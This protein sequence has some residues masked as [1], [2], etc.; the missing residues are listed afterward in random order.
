M[1]NNKYI[2]RLKGGVLIAVASVMIASCNDTWDDHYKVT[3]LSN[4]KTLWTNIQE[5]SE[6]AE[7]AR[8]L[9]ACGYDRKLGSAEM[10]TV[11]APVIDQ[12]TADEWIAT[13][14]EDEEK[15][16]KQEDNRTVVQFL[17]NHIALYNRS[18]P[19]ELSDSITLVNGKN[20]KMTTRYVASEPVYTYGTSEF[21][22]RNIVASN[23][24]L[25]KLN[26][27]EAYFPNIWE[28]IQMEPDFTRISAYISSFNDYYLDT[29]ASVPGG[30]NEDGQIEYLDSVTYFYNNLLSSLGYINREDSAY[31]MIVPTDEVWDVTL[32][33]YKSYFNFV[34]NYR[35][36]DSV[37]NARATLCILQDLTF[38]KNSQKSI[39]DSLCSSCY[40]PLLP[41]IHVFKKPFEEGGILYGADKIQASN[42][43]LYRVDRFPI[44]PQLSFM[45]K[46]ELEAESERNYDINEKSTNAFSR[47]VPST[48][49]FKVSAGRFLEISP[50]SNNQTAAVNFQLSSILSGCYYDIY[51]VFVP[52]IAYNPNATEAE[53]RPYSL[54]F[55]LKYRRANES[56]TTVDLENPN[57]SGW[58]PYAYTTRPDVMD[59]VLIAKNRQFPICNIGD[60]TS[61]V[62]LIARSPSYNDWSQYSNRVRID[63]VLLVPHPEKED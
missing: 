38:N 24:V 15:R 52:A 54:E 7:F 46:Q 32:E 59:T 27:P 51:C 55:Q 56:E 49:A 29:E 47:S 61:I 1:I 33:Q 10:Y 28:Y 13:Y 37:Q 6:L 41:G 20:I 53:R 63:C 43:E 21:I 62:E 50:T 25:H 42:G 35:K 34:S 2:S 60:N 14:Q 3:D 12:E 16:V 48:S 30:V 44:D 19:E 23:G 58:D 8:V 57:P 40:N 9:Q 39:E 5:D 4:H 11:F 17:N 31:L 22:Q 45:I 18:L 36:R 26:A